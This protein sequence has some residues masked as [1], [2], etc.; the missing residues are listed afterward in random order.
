MTG[1]ELGHQVSL[2]SGGG[3]W[4]RRRNLQGGLTG[5]QMAC[6]DPAGCALSRGGTDVAPVTFA[7]IDRHQAAVANAPHNTATARPIEKHKR[8]DGI[9]GGSGNR[10]DLAGAECAA[11]AV[12]AR[13]VTTVI[14]ASLAV[15]LGSTAGQC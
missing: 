1:K 11:T 3:F 13:T 15:S 2:E 5:A 4:V 8:I 10:H 9:A 14:I 7:V 12:A 6:L